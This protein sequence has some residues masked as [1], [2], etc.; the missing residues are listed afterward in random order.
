MMRK[1]IISIITVVYTIAGLGAH[2]LAKEI[3]STNVSDKVKVIQLYRNDQT[4]YPY[5]VIEEIEVIG[6][7]SDQ[8]RILLK[9]KAIEKGA[10]AIIKFE[11]IK[12]AF[13]FRTKGIAIRWKGN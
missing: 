13:G 12:S 1:I 7:Q 10:D 3:H 4:D 5:E 11:S 6:L 9:E 8:T 2:C